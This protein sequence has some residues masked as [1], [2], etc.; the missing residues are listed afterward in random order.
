MR[1]HRVTPRAATLSRPLTGVS[2][3]TR[4]RLGLAAVVLRRYGVVFTRNIGCAALFLY[5]IGWQVDAGS[6]FT[7]FAVVGLVL[8][9]GWNVWAIRFT[10]RLLWDEVLLDLPRR[11]R[12]IPGPGPGTWATDVVAARGRQAVLLLHFGRRREPKP[13]RA[14]GVPDEPWGHDARSLGRRSRTVVAFEWAD[15]ARAAQAAAARLQPPPQLSE[16]R[17]E[18]I[19]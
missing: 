13:Q 14:H 12:A 15:D 19:S 6:L 5:G 11:R 10:T 8:L 16:P 1:R 2:P 7:T 18:R 9:T 17:R 3:R 4:D